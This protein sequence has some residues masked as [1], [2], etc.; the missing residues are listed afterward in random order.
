MPINC[1]WHIA[2]CPKTLKTY[3]IMEPAAPGYSMHRS[4]VNQSIRADHMGFVVI[5]APKQR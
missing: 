2:R 5:Y 3:I 1:R 4:S